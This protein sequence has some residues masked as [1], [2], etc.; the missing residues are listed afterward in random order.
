MLLSQEVQGYAKTLASGSVQKGI[1][2]RDLKSYEFILPKEN[3]KRIL[4]SLLIPTIA[5]IKSNEKEIRK[6]TN[7]RDTLLPK[8]MS[9]ELDISKIN[10]DL[11]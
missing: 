11:E 1:R 10:Y 3:D 2:M 9:G 8:L 6:L 7:L 4:D 5:N